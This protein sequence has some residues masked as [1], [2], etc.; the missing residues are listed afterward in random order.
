V[1]KTQVDTIRAS[2]MALNEGDVQGALDA[3]HRDAVWHESSE[4]PEG[5]EF[6]GRAE[7]EKFLQDFLEQWEVFH[8]QIESTLHEGDRVLVNIHL[9]AVGRASGVEVNVRYAHVWTMREDRAERVDAFYD[10]EKALR[11]LET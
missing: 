11:E 3:L 1:A 7:I 9:T 5:D 2:Y 4:L 10:P 8:Q 6:I